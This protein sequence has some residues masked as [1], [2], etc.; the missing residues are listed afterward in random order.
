MKQPFINGP[1]LEAL[2][3]MHMQDGTKGKC[4]EIFWRPLC[5]DEE[6]P[7]KLGTE[8]FEVCRKPKYLNE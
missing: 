1:V 3:L 5:T 7:D 8:N 4:T 2:I 6:K